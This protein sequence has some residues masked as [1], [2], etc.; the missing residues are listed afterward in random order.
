MTG[1]CPP[2][3]NTAPI[4][5]RI[6]K[7]SRILLALNSLKL[8]AQS[9]PWS[10]NALPIAAS[11]S[12]SS[13]CRA[14][15]A[16][17]IGGKASS[18]WSTEWNS[19]W[20]GYSGSCRAFLDFQ[21]SMA[22]FEEDLSAFVTTGVVVAVAVAADEEGFG[23][24]SETMGFLDGSGE[25]TAEIGLIDLMGFRLV[26]WIWVWKDLVGI[27][28]FVPVRAIDSFLDELRDWN[29]KRVPGILGNGWR[30]RYLKR[31]EREVKGFYNEGFWG[32]WWR[33]VVV[34]KGILGN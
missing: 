17:T 10:K 28:E 21:L 19:S 31:G 34:G 7:V 33:M 12:R 13:R 3:I 24:L 9:P 22:H 8:S 23:G 26:G 15:P 1:T 25:W 6:L 14:S 20:S 16:N 27:R 4:W 30:S 2:N 5:R 18:V 11:P 29:C 32:G